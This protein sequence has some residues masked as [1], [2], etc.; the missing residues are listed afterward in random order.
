[1]HTN[2]FHMKH[3]NAMVQAI[4]LI[5]Y[6]R[7]HSNLRYSTGAYTTTHHAG[8]YRLDIYKYNSLSERFMVIY[9]F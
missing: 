4:V 7:M 5:A 2:W 6:A 8:A 1:M 9:G 3:A